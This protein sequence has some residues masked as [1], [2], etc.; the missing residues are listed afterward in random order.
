MKY[1]SAIRNNE[2]L[3]F[4]GKWMN[5]KNLMLSEVSQVQKDKGGMI[6]HMCGRYIQIQLQA[7][8]YEHI[9]TE[10]ISNSGTVIGE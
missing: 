5:L 4:T 8:P 1:Y 3:S 7:L 9:Y 2:I 10:H 6:S